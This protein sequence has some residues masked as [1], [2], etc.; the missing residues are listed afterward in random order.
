M[1]TIYGYKN[2]STVR[3]AKKFLDASNVEYRHIDN[4]ED[5]LSQK[6]LE[7]IF[8]KS[9]KE[10]VRALFNTSGMKYRELKLKDKIPGMSI[11]EVFDILA[12]DGMLVKRPIF[13]G[14]NG[15]VLIGFNEKEW[16]EKILD[17][18]DS[19]SIK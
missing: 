17:S 11:D 5:K 12:T 9:G 14:E 15:L 1:N 7:E 2:C 19:S 10:N 6:E 3:K 18:T 13:L 4:V 16:T 8:K